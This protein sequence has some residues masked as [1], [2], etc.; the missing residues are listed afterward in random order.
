MPKKI[1]I[2]FIVGALLVIT[3][4]S[5]L[6]SLQCG[7]TNWDDDRYVIENTLI[8]HLSFQS[9]GRIFTSFAI[10]NYHPLTLLTFAVEHH[11]FKL[12]P[13]PYHLTNIILHMGNVLLV[14]FLGYV[15]TKRWT[16]A[17]M[18]ALLFGVHPLRVESVTWIVERKDVLSSLFYLGALISYVFYVRTDK[19]KARFYVGALAFFL[20][21]LLSKS[22]AITLPVLFLAFDFFL[23]RK[24]NK[25]L[26]I[27]KIPFFFLSF[28]FGV[29][30]LLSVDS[31]QGQDRVPFGLLER[32]FMVCYRLEVYIFKLFVPVKLSA[33]YPFP[34]AEGGFWFITSPLIILC[35]GVMLYRKRHLNFNRDIIFGCLFFIIPMLLVLQIL[36]WFK[37]VLA[38]RYTYLSSIGLFFIVARAVTYLWDKN[39]VRRLLVVVMVGWVGTLSIATFNRCL[40]WNNSGTLWTDVI[41]KYPG[42]ALAHANRGN[43]YKD[44]KKYKQALIDLNNAI[45]INSKYAATYT[46]RGIVY[47]DTGQYPLAMKDFN[48]AIVID[49]EHSDAYNNRG[50]LYRVVYKKYDLAFRD[51][52]M[53]IELSPDFKQVY[54]NRGN[55]YRE[56]GQHHLALTEYNKALK[57]DPYYTN[58]YLNRGNLYSS[59]QQFDLA[60]ADY[61]RVLELNPQHAAGYNNRGVLYKNSGQF[62]L[63]LADYNHA[64]VINPEFPDAY[65]NRANIYSIFKKHDKALKDVLKAKSLGFPIDKKY[66]ED[67][68][69]LADKK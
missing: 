59:L 67:L 55:A 32:I 14:F 12:N 54:N 20:L 45:A 3:F 41:N 68:E 39:K 69:Q 38:D 53:A 47:K 64:L 62:N 25:Q 31:G 48:Q 63:A 9:V 61:A 26:I 44:E 6:P 65:K 28:V 18:V 11:F 1:H 42:I 16:T 34:E 4:I 36:P 10:G 33:L 46:T 15:L 51:Y 60:L 27:E 57:A 30:G 37:I 66:L 17:L 2:G 50:N 56:L 23:R 29:L 5:F 35:V 58:T 40:V 43:F 8:H 19:L 22:Y 24:W 13:L 7:F 21:S 52:K 49:P